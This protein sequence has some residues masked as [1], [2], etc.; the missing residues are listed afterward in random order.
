MPKFEP[1]ANKFTAFARNDYSQFGEDGIVEAILSCLSSTDKWCVEFGAWDG[2]HLSNTYSLIKSKSYKSVLIEADT[3]K[4]KILTKNMKGFDATLVNEFV[5]FDGENTLD[6][7]L[8]KTAIPK[9]FDF[10]SIDIDG[11]DYHIL[12]SISLYKPK[13]I[14][15]ECNPTI[16]NEV[17]YIQPKDFNVKHG[18]SALAIHE[19]AVGKGYMLAASTTCN[20][21]LVDKIYWQMLGLATSNLVEI[22]DDSSARVFM[23]SGYD[24]TVHLSKP[25]DLLWHGFSADE[26]WF[27]VLPKYLRRFS[28]DYSLFEKMLFALFKIKRNPAS[29]FA[30][31]RSKLGV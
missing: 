25:L 23:F 21:I 10:L 19:L 1:T 29:F 6:K 27:Q 24:G 8:G 18:S 15:I 3:E 30:R 26:S 4:F 14:C 20:L 7:I 5:T 28:P 12:E 16:P 2:L 9:D 31:V 11:N 13:V 17:A 22:R